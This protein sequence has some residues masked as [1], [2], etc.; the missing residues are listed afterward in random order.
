MKRN[1]VSL[2]FS[3]S[4]NLCIILSKFSAL[5]V[6]SYKYLSQFFLSESRI[7]REFSIGPKTMLEL[8]LTAI[9]DRDYEGA[10]KCLNKCIHDYS[11]YLFENIVL[12]RAYGGL[13]IMGISIEQQNADEAKRNYEQNL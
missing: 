9:E 3:N 6:E 8:G 11:G 4:I 5:V 12:L 7:G 2:K 10:E 1:S 13:R